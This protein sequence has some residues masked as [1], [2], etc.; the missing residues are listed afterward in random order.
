MLLYEHEN[1][2][3][4]PRHPCKS[5]ARWLASVI[6]AQVDT[7]VHESAIL[8]KMEGSMFSEKPC[9]KKVVNNRGRHPTLTPDLHMHT[10][11]CTCTYIHASTTYKTT[12]RDTG[13]KAVNL[14]QCSP[15]PVLSHVRQHRRYG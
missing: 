3:S 8:A 11:A 4:S 10:E 5:S 7:R 2:S 13:N 6:L 14:V 9:L 12:C 1:L 15:C